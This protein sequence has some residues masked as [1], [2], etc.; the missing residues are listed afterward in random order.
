MLATFEELLLS[1]PPVRPSVRH[2]L[3]LADRSFTS[4]SLLPQGH[5]C[6]HPETQ[7]VLCLR[8]L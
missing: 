4:A 3:E 8:P 2:T 1:C 5:A 6:G 7:R